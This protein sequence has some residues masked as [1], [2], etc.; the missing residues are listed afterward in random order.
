MTP[1]V[2]LL[3]HEY[4]FHGTC[5]HD[6]S[7]EDP[8][9]YFGKALELHSK[10]TLPDKKLNYSEKSIQWFVAN[11]LHLK[12]DAIQYYKRG[13]EWQFCYDNKF[14]V[15]TCPYNAEKP[16]TDPK[17]SSNCTVKGN[18]SKDSDKK[19]YFTSSHPNYSSVVI[20][21][22]RGERCFSTEDEAI[23]AGWV[24]AP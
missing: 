4:E 23:Q 24:K 10:L 16:N 7:L 18:I 15:M 5:M 12:A 19:Y 20:T 22:S 11:N 8:E 6:E 1:S 21:T 3:Q 14:K 13:Q 17:P 9:T 2:W